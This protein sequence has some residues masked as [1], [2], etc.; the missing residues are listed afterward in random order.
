VP[1]GAYVLQ[2]AECSVRNEYAV[3]VARSSHFISQ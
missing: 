2:E 3:S 1:P